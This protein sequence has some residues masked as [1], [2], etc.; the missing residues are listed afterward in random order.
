MAVS[1]TAVVDVDGEGRNG[2]HVRSSDGL[3]E[4]G[5]A[6]PKEL[7]GAGTATNPEQLL[8]A[9][10]AACFLG[11]LR[12]AATTR[13]IWL[14]STTITRSPCTEPATPSDVLTPPTEERG[15]DMASMTHTHVQT[16]PQPRS[17]LH[18]VSG[19]V[20]SRAAGGSEDR[21]WPRDTQVWNWAEGAAFSGYGPAASS[22]I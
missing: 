6:L 8:A 21:D 12:R 7:G 18:R 13:K 11:A 2:G 15:Q 4:T 14:T 20:P 19:E 1:Y 3:L 16:A 9:G 10:W 17:D 5:L 22:F